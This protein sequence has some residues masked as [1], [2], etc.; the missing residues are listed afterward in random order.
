MPPILNPV[1]LRH[2]AICAAFAFV[3][4]PLWANPPSWAG[5]G[6][7]SA[8]KTAESKSERVSAA[9][10]SFTVENR[11][12]AT[13]YFGNAARPGKCPPGLAKKNNGC[14][15]PGQ[16]KKWQ[17]GAPLAGDVVFYALPRELSIKLPLPP[18][19]HRYVRVARDILLIT[20]GTKMVVD[21][22]EDILR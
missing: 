6:K 20:I 15:P 8:G 7:H 22:M 1:V 16:A 21:A 10:F 17:K 18:P 11:R 13:D 9:S 14:Q 4:T 3:I 19:D 2:C 5:Q 12:V